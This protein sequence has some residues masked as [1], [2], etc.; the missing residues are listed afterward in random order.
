MEELESRLVLSSFYLVTSTADASGHAS[1]GGTGTQADPLQVDSLRSAIEL[2]N[3]DSDTDTIVVP[4]GTYLLTGGELGITNS[5]SIVGDST[6][7][8]ILD[9]NSASRV[10]NVQFGTVNISTVT[11]QNGKVQGGNQTGADVFGGGI[12][13]NGGSLTLT[14]S[15]VTGNQAIGGTNTNVYA[16]Q[17]GD[18]NG[19]GIANIGGTLTVK[20]STIAY[21]SA[22]GGT[23][24]TGGEGFGGDA[25]GGGIYASSDTT[26][27]NS[28]IA[29]NSASGS[30]GSLGNGTGDGGEL[31]KRPRSPR[32]NANAF[33]SAGRDFAGWLEQLGIS[34]AVMTSLAGKNRVAAG[35]QNEARRHETSRTMPINGTVSS[36]KTLRPAHSLM[37]VTDFGRNDPRRGCFE[38]S[39]RNR[40]RAP[41]TI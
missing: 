17:A 9:G 10:F 21:N 40:D 32:G 35:K 39:S 2:A 30:N 19:G 28:T 7:P 37:V 5:I 36:N 27:Q 12:L 1:S 41:T 34:I 38:A 11:I 22:L 31:G 3:G 25:E 6:A 20:N 14:G 24:F 4:N 23:G 29:F 26:I 18:G 16:S 13:V 15:T 33:S 8:T